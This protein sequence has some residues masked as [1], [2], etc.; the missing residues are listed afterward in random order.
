M[1][2]H[3]KCVG[4]IHA[5]V[6]FYSYFLSSSLQEIY[7]EG[8]TVVSE[9]ASRLFPSMFTSHQKVQKVDDPRA[10]IIKIGSTSLKVIAVTL[11]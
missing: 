5:H 6:V 1:K 8:D 3:F 4:F 7:S 2:T 10:R 9:G 11:L